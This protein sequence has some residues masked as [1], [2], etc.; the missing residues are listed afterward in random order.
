VVKYVGYLVAKHDAALA[1]AGGS[2]KLYDYTY[3]YNGFAAKL[4]AAQAGKLAADSG[5]VAV[6]PD[7]LHEMD[8]SSTPSFSGSPLR[9][10]SGTSSAA[11]A[12]PARA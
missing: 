8:T 3:T 12:A 6:T 1:K 4:S 11:S 10:A 5:V 7:E 9:V 2:T